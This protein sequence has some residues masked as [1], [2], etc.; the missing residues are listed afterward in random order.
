MKIFLWTSFGVLVLMFGLLSQQKKTK[1]FVILSY[2]IYHGEH[3]YQKNQSNVT[4]VAQLIRKINPDLVAMQEVDSMTLRTA[5][6]HDGTKVNLMQEWAKLTGMDSFFAKAI[7]FSEGAYGEG[8]LLGYPAITESL[9]LP[10]PLGGEGRALALAT[11]TLDDGSKLSFGGTHLCHE[12]EE[13]RTAQVTAILAHVEKMDHPLI[14]AGD[15]NFEMD[16]PGYAKMS[17]KF[18]DTAL[19]FGK[20][21]ATYSS[22][23]PKIRIDYIWLSK[24]HPWQIKS[25]KVLPADYSDHLPLLVE[26][27][28]GFL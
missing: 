7:T 5:T 11:L 22:K 21:Q 13:N 14:I 18:F 16:A 28:L 19:E 23:D 1:N 15:F 20:P 27:S 6:L 10:T 24:N 2:N 9:S 12:F 8:L 26:V 4:Q 25:A 17:E 3:P